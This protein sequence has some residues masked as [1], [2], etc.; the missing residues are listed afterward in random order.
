[1]EGLVFILFMAGLYLLP[2]LVAV[3]NKKRNMAAVAVLNIFLGWTF[4]G[5]IVALVWATCKDAEAK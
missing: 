3:S 1:M 4:L 5:W 2:T